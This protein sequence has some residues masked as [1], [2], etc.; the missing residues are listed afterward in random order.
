MSYLCLYLLLLDR[1]R[2]LDIFCSVAA[3]YQIVLEE[4]SLGLFSCILLLIVLVPLAKTQGPRAV[5]GFG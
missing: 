3:V 1:K 5:L 4:R 2:S